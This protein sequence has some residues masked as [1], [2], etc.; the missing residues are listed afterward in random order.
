[1]HQEG[2]APS[3]GDPN[4]WLRD[5]GDCY[6]Y[7]CVYVDDLMAIMKD[8]GQFFTKIQDPNGYGFKMKGV[9]PP[10]YHL[11]GNFGY[12]DDGTLWYGSSTYVDKVMAAY[13]QHFGS[14]PSYK[15]IGS[16]LEDGDHPELDTSEILD[17]DGK[18]VYMSLVG[19]LQWAVTL[20]RF[21][22]AYAVMVLSRFRVE[23]RIGHLD[24][25][26][27]VCGYLRKHPDARIRFRTHV[28]KYDNW[29]Q[30]V[31]A[32]WMYSVYGERELEEYE[33]MPKPKGALVTLAMFIDSG[34]NHCRVTGKASTGML[35]S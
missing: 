25:V 21:D 34:I 23:P 30:K 26:K 9:G 29:L 12:D 24:W 33:G 2:F 13:E 15:K 11:G 19:C 31:V 6:E 1:M 7:V 14:L 17:E 35:Q 5:T 27:R 32:D 20:N 22:I 8:P 16:P 4:V 28:P 10:R 18:A 3:L